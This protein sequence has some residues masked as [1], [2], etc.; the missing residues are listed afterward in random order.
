MR[1]QVLGPVTAHDD[2]GGPVALRGPRYREVLARL[3]LADRRVVP[4]SRLVDDLWDEPPADAV[5][6]VRT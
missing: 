5:G 1:F 2:L 6:A 4:V 3:I